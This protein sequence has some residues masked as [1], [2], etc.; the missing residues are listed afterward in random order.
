MLSL[1]QQLQG[2]EDNCRKAQPK[3]VVK[4][5]GGEKKKKTDRAK[6]VNRWMPIFAAVGYEATSKQ[7]ANLRGLS[8]YA[9]N[10]MLRNMENE[11][12]PLVE[13]AGTVPNGKCRPMVLWRWIGEAK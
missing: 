5:S 4:V 12:P 8:I 10:P 13:R 3:R 9:I 6:R 2:T 7:L 1:L 11:N